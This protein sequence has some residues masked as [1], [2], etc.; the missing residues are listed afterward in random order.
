MR[1][2]NVLISI[3]ASCFFCHAALA[4]TANTAVQENKWDIQNP[5]YS[6]K[7]RSADI[8]VREG[9]WLSLDVSPDGKT[10][11]F[12][13]LGDLYRLPIDGGEA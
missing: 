5:D 10:I 8:D 1:F 7:P 11:V 9:T 3:L 4:A 6:V 12:D 2:S 13:L